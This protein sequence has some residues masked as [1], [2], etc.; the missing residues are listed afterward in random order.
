MSFAKEIGLA[1]ALEKRLSHLKKRKRGYCVSEKILSFVEMLIKG[2]L[3][4]SPKSGQV[5]KVYFD[6]PN[7]KGG[8]VKWSTCEKVMMQHLE[9]KWL[10]KQLRE[11]ELWL[12]FPVN[13]GFMPTRFTN[14]RN[15]YWKHFRNSLRVGERKRIKI[16][17]NW[18]LSFIGRSVS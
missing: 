18:S 12:N 1:A 10:W 11:S 9:P 5:D 15:S 2:G 6:L 4:V 8:M 3:N 16:P 7:L 14:G 13:L 17:R